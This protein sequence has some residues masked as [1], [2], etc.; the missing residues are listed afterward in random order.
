VA[1]ALILAGAVAKG[2]YTAGVV[3]VLLGQEGKTQ[4][5][6]EVHS[7]VAASSGALNGAYVAAALHAGDEDEVIGR[8]TEMWKD[9]GS[10]GQVFEPTF[11]GIL[12]R[13]GASG[14]QKVFEILRRAIKPAPG[15]REIELRLV[16]ASLT[17]TTE[18]VGGAPATTFERV[19]TFGKHT[20][21]KQGELEKMF[22]VV[23]ASAALP[24]AFVPVPLQIDGVEVL[25]VDGGAVNN[26]P[27]RS[28]LEHPLGVD[29]I[30]VVTPQPR[31][32]VGLARDTKG[33][34]LVSHLV[35]MLTEER[36]FRDLRR[37]FE[38]NRI[39]VELE[40]TVPDPAVRARVLA[41]LGW[42]GRKPIDI[43]EIRPPKALPG[44]M[45]DGFF[46][47]DLREEYVCAGEEAARAW[48]ASL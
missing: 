12:G 18:Q 33:L 27:L 42:E 45:F 24:G 29:R 1:D 28:A 32:S 8:L 34:G 6:V 20:F 30:F 40:K 25:C 10:F 23:T 19:L 41:T 4:A 48:L 36:L 37:S 13:R 5:H 2:A 43:V 15:I 31:V 11:E 3:S 38:V 21:E 9:S 17:G 46:S 44:N 26:T 35:E 39:L 16:V 7:V 14:E 47:R 22:R